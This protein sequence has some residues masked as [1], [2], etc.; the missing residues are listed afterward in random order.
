MATNAPLPP[1]GKG[2]ATPPTLGATTGR[3]DVDLH[4]GEDA[5]DQAVLEQEHQSIPCLLRGLT[6]ASDRTTGTVG[7]VASR[8]TM[9]V[10][11]R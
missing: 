9:Y 2:A 1:L 11:T 6:C 3:A 7:T 8:L 5:V 4:E 10:R